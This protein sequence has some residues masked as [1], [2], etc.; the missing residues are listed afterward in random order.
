MYAKAKIYAQYI[1]QNKL[2]INDVPKKYRAD[3][4]EWAWKRY[5]I[6]IEMPEE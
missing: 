1:F 6:K 2:T 5:G 4:I 3:T